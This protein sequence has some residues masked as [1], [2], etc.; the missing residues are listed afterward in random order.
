MSEKSPFADYREYL[1]LVGDIATQFAAFESVV[2]ETIWTIANLNRR[3]GA[4]IT[5]QIISVHTKFRILRALLHEVEAQPS[6]NQQLNDLEERARKN[7]DHRNKYVHSPMGLA[8]EDGVLVPIRYQTRVEGTL[9]D[10][11]IPFGSDKSEMNQTII[12]SQE[13]KNETHNLKRAIELHLEARDRS[14]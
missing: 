9:S 13:L 11:L 2:D 4:C 12:R 8:V 1:T 5:S 10:E 6:I 14:L 3:M 7:S